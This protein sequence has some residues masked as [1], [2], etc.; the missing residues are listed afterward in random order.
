MQDEAPA[1]G[2]VEAML[3][4]DSPVCP[5]C[6]VAG[7]ACELKGVRSKPSEKRP[8]GKVWRGLKKCLSNRQHT[9]GGRSAADGIGPSVWSKFLEWA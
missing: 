2:H 4:P 5:H 9:L 6:G 1:F 7:E 8:E 3:R